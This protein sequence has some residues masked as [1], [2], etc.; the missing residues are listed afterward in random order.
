MIGKVQL[1]TL[2]PH[3]GAMCLLDTVEEWSAESITCTTRTHLS[4]DNP[5]H[6]DGRLAALHAIEYAA[7]AMAIHGALAAN[8]KYGNVPRQGF[9]VAVRDVALHVDRLDDL[10]G[11]LIVRATQRLANQDG[12]IYNFAVTHGE[13][14]LCEGRI[15][16]AFT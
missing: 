6:R 9:L 12:S 16:V 15:V 5:L 1:Q 10:L 3:A 8:G 2:L 14:R 7:Q 11:P 4:N 13:Q